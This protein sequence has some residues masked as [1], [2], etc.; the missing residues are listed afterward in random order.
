M[1]WYK[2][3]SSILY[4]QGLEFGNLRVYKGHIFQYVFYTK[5]RIFLVRLAMLTTLPLQPHLV[6]EAY[7]T[8][9]LPLHTL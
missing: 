1:V 6:S 5:K 3:E 8:G 4:G 7:N 9:S 2:E